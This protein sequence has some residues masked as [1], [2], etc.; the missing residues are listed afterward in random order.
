[1]LQ[2]G[3]LN[4]LQGCDEI[5]QNLCRHHDAVTVGANFLCNAHHTTA[6]IALQVNEKGLSVRNNL[7]C[8]NNIVVHVW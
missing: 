3:F 5:I 4:V 7:L 2:I 6:S 8:A 1:M